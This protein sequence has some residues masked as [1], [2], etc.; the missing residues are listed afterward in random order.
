MTEEGGRDWIS[1]KVIYGLVYFSH[2]CT[3]HMSHIRRIHTVFFVPKSKC[4]LSQLVI[5]ITKSRTL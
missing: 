3:T 1:F 5:Y 4:L 2:T